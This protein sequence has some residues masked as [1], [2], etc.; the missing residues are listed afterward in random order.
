MNEESQLTISTFIELL[1]NKLAKHGDLPVFL[2]DAETG[3]RF[4]LKPIHVT[5]D[6]DALEISVQYSDETES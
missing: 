2:I 4:L 5:E 6:T 1:Q 3:W